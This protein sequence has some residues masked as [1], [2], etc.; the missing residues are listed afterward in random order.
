MMANMQATETRPRINAFRTALRSLV[1]GR[2]VVAFDAD[3]PP[4]AIVI[5][6]RERA[7]YHVGA[8]RIAVRYPIAIGSPTEEWT[9]LEF[10]TDKK[11]NPP[12]HPVPELGKEIRDPVLGGDPTNPLGARA[13]YLGRT[14]WRIHGT[15]AAESIGRAVSNGCI[16]MHNEHVVELY[17]NVMLGT[18]VY[19]IDSLTDPRPARRG[20]KT[21]DQLTA[22]IPRS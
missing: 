11:V 5:V 14:L 20:R 21:Q 10:V 19:V 17:E 3:Y 12:W 6:N 22:G 16:R 13:L 7:L 9:G 4:G 1:T 8:E 15:P 2:R 18:E